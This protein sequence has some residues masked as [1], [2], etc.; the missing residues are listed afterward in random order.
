M[1]TNI[2]LT[3]DFTMQD[4]LSTEFVHYLKDY[5]QDIVE[6]Q[7]IAKRDRKDEKHPCPDKRKYSC[8]EAFYKVK[9]NRDKLCGL[10]EAYYFIRKNRD[11]DWSTVKFVEKTTYWNKKTYLEGTCFNHAD[12]K[13]WKVLKNYDWVSFDV[14]VD[15]I[16]KYVEDGNKE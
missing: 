13:D 2:D 1:K 5:I 6:D 14:L 15:V 4:I 12:L 10:Y 11:F 8:Y 7:K 9:N 16:K 3:K